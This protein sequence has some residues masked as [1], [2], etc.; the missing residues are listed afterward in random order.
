MSNVNNRKVTRKDLCDA[1]L[2]WLTTN[3]S[4]LNPSWTINDLASVTSA[5]FGVGGGSK[6]CTRTVTRKDSYLYN[7]VSI[8]TVKSQLLAYLRDRIDPSFSLTD[9]T[10]VLDA[11]DINFL[12]SVLHYFVFQKV[13]T[14]VFNGP[15]YGASAVKKALLY[16]VHVVLSDNLNITSVAGV[17][18]IKTNPVNQLINNFTRNLKVN[19]VQRSVEYTES[20]SYSSCCSSSSCSSS[21]SAFLAHIQ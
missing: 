16:D 15:F 12:E 7:T 5:S 9:T 14:C 21:C 4:N 1:I 20:R 3:V 17:N 6:G 2:D 18:T 11:S 10:T 19:N 13:V 8:E